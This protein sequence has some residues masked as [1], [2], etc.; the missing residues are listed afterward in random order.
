M[1]SFE[2][3][4]NFRPSELLVK[5]AGTVHGYRDMEAIQV[6]NNSVVTHN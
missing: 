2:Q 5:Y 1:L 6:E 3:T 4:D